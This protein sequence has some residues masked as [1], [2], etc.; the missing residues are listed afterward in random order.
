[1]AISF[2]LHHSAGI[3]I[4]L[5]CA[6]IVLVV[7]LIFLFVRYRQ[8]S[9]TIAYLTRGARAASLE[10][11]IM[12]HGKEIDIL[13]SDIEKIRA[14]IASIRNTLTKSI[15]RKSIVRYNPFKDL[16]GNQSFAIAF[17]DGNNNGI[18]VSSL[19]TREGT[20]I[21]AKPIVNAASPYKLSEEEERAVRNAL[22]EEL[23]VS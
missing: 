5:A 13:G 4:A 16:G 22:K 19:H 7:F 15:W 21:Y 23:H 20:R 17:L 8:L 3:I 18:V 11:I 10:D 2:I 6:V 14:E 1:M 9:A 12:M